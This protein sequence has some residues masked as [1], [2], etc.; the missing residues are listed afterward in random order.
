[1][2]ATTNNIFINSRETLERLC[3]ASGRLGIVQLPLFRAAADGLLAVVRIE[4]PSTPWPAR[5]VERYAHRPT[6]F[7]LGADPGLEHPDPPPPSEWVCARRLK[8][9]AQH[10]AAVVHGAA[11]TPDDYRQAAH[12]TMVVGRTAFIETTSARID[13]WASFLSAR[14]M[15]IIRPPDGQQHPI[16]APQEALQ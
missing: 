11:G 2:T 6:C 3:D 7:M 14:K 1:M 5:G 13:E 9:W 10:S 12:L 16:A 15:I 8:Y 4:D